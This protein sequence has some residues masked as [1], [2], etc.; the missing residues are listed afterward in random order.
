MLLREEITLFPGAGPFSLTGRWEWIDTAD[1]RTAST[2]VDLLTE[3]RVL[4]A[5]NALGPR[6]T[7]E[8][9]GT[10]EK[11]A[12][13]GSLGGSADFDLRRLELEEELVWQPHPSRRFSGRA[14]VTRE[15][16]E[17]DGSA[18]RAVAGGL[19]TSVSFRRSGRL[20]GDVS[21]THPTSQEGVASTDRF[22]TRDT[23]DLAWRTSLELRLSEA[24]T[25]SLT[26]TGRALEGV[27]PTHNARAQMRALF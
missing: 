25:A 8:S 27:P 10:W 11:D 22:R 2:R 14:A 12:R 7:L 21:W 17:A 18:I 3:R 24:I 1:N 20:Q 4:R 5:R 19:A 23:D 26:Y 16:N 15:R 13:A 9:Q 6:W